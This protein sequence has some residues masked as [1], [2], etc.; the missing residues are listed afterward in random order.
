MK[1]NVILAGVL[2]VAAACA[3][4]SG[5]AVGAENWTEFRGPTGQGH[6]KAQ[7]L[8]SEW[9]ATNQVA[10][11]QSLP[12][13]GWSSPVTLDGRLYL[14]TAVPQEAGKQSL[15]VLCLEAKTGKTVWDVEVFAKAITKGHQKNSQAS[16]TPVIEGERLY[17]HFGH[18]GTACLDLAGQTVWKNETL[19]YSPVHGNGGSPILCDDALIFSSDG[20]SEPFIAALHKATGERLWK[21]T[22]VTDAKR[23]FSFN[24]PLAI[25]AGGRKQVISCGSGAVFSYD[26]KSGKELWRVRYGE[27]YSVVPRAV[28]GHGLVFVSSGFDHPVV[29]AIRPDGAGDVTDTHV[30]WTL[31]KGGPTTPSLLLD[32]DELYFVS[33]AGIASCVDA[34]TG[35]VHWSERLKG[36]YSASPVL[37]DGKIYFQSEE[38]VGVVLKPGR[39]FQKLAENPL[40]ERTL[41]S[42]AVADGAIFIRGDKHLFRIQATPSPG[43]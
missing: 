18:L 31:A 13:A 11:K 30:A 26:P 7:H 10:W 39:Q 16:P 3:A 32:G 27:G 5:A 35:R 38:G 41:S 37:A 21:T 24:T 22:R 15:R 8:P 36:N 1:S 23:K 28:F 33:D 2:A 19:S 9:S 29:M 25:T 43:H 4:P 40:G 34:K 6:S 20:A 12:G 14:T 17:V 42:Y